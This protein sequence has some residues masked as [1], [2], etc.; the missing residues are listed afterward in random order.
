M[1][2]ATVETIDAYNPATGALVGSVRVMDAVDVAAAIASARNGLPDWAALDLRARGRHLLAVRTAIVK[3]GPA[4]VD[5][6]RKETGKPEADAW[7]EVMVTCVL[8]G[9]VGRRGPKVLKPTRVA[10]W[11]LVMKR[12]S[13]TYA[14]YGVVGVI[15]P[16][17]YPLLAPM[18]AI[19]SS[20]GAGNTVVLKPSEL[21]PLTGRLL[22]DV[23]NSA[24]REL[25]QVV[26]GYGPTGAAL[27]SGGVDKVAFTGSP[28]TGRRIL[29]AAANTLTPVVMELGGKD[30]VIVCAD[31]NIGRAARAAVFGAFVNAGQTCAA[32][33]R[34][35]VEAPAYESFVSQAV[36]ATERLRVGPD[37]AA[38]VGPIIRHEQIE[39]LDR[40]VADAEAKGGKVMT[41]GGRLDELPPNFFPPTIIRDANPGMLVMQHETFGPILPI[42][43]VR[44]CQEALELANSSEFGLGS[45]VFAGKRGTA[46]LLAEQLVTG[47]VSINDG[48][49]GVMVAGLPFGGVKSSGYGRLQGA[50]G[51][52][53][54][55]RTKSVVEGRIG[56]TFSLAA[57]MAAP[58]RPTGRQ[59]DR[60]LRLMFGR[61][62]RG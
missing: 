29:A 47:G 40:L 10:P 20:L 61:A 4:L 45:S 30:P 14:P 42:M 37:A 57:L 13:I 35:F 19:A 11:P 31:A 43:R 12:A 60:L 8:L 28:A 49:V 55:S 33:Q 15:S 51:L 34:V 39:L 6:I 7:L 9:Y 26:T 56:H 24:G 52:R 36:D 59:V 16:W 48:A 38:Q 32:V 5:S 2:E 3:N 27:I 46:R 62:G 25:V 17:N 18:Q 21:T 50:A 22:G 53:E 44:S 1:R 41:G 54:F 58:A 23:I